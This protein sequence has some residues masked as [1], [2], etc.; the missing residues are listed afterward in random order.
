MDKTTLAK[1][2]L[3]INRQMILIGVEAQE[4]HRVANEAELASIN[5][6]RKLRDQLDK[7]FITPDL[8]ELFNEGE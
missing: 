6:L 1:V 7:Q 2:I 8:S 5:E 3:M 4:T